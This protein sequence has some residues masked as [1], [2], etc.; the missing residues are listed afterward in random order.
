MSK[1]E[2]AQEAFSLFSTFGKHIIFRP[3]QRLLG[4]IA[5]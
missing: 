5:G 3:L 1:P 2:A 4:A